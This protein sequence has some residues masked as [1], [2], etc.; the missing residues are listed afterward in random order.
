[1]GCKGVPPTNSLE[2]M[3]LRKR[4]RVEGEDWRVEGED[5]KLGF[6]WETLSCLVIF[7]EHT[8]LINAAI[9]KEEKERWKQAGS[10]N[11]VYWLLFYSTL[12]AARH[13]YPQHE[14]VLLRWK[15]C[16]QFVSSKFI[17]FTHCH[18]I[19]QKVKLRLTLLTD[20]RITTSNPKS[21]AKSDGINI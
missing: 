10:V 16:I 17:Y 4:R 15:S 21:I 3:P 7:F 14:K 2:A 12:L 13:Q 19:C 18:L 6:G 11:C 8:L 9:I 5:S 20:R 1:M